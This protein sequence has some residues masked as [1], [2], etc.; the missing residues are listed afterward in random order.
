MVYIY[1]RPD[2]DQLQFRSDLNENQ[3]EQNYYGVVTYQKSAGDLNYQASVF[4]R[5]S[6]V[7]FVPDSI[8]DLFYN[9]VAS[10]VKRTLYSGGI[11]ADA[12]YELNDQHTFRGRLAV[13]GRNGPGQLDD[14]GLSGG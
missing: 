10:D 1:A 4:G 6:S 14:H 8:G 5:N 7:H 9:G 12:S 13:S 3:N 11:Q 2:G